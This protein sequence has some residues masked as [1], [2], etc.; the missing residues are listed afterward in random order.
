[1]FYRGGYQAEVT[2]NATGY[3]TEKKYD[4]FEAQIKSRLKEWGALD[5][6][7]ILEFQRC[8]VPQTNPRTQL[9]AT[10]YLRVFMQANEPEAIY[11][12]LKAHTYNAMQHFAG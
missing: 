12:F 9:S 4:L 1:M 6:F 10:T 5:K 2:I 3:A 7:Q 11:Q 8:G